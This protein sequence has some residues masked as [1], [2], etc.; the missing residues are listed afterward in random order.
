[1]GQAISNAGMVWGYA[2]LPEGGTHGLL[3]HNGVI[4]DISPFMLPIFGGV[5]DHG[6][7]AGT[8]IVQAPGPD[9]SPPQG[10]RAVRCQAI[11]E[12][13]V[14]EELDPLPNYSLGSLAMG[15]NTEGV[16]VGYSFAGPGRIFPDRWPYRACMWNGGVVTDL[17]DE[18]SPGSGWSLNV[19]FAINDKGQIAGWGEYEG[20]QRA[21]RLDPVGSIEIPDDEPSI[22]PDRLPDL[23]AHIL[24]GIADGGPGVIVLPGTGPIPIGP[25]GFRRWA[26][27][28][29][30]QREA[31][32]GLAMH[33]IASHLPDGD[34]RRR[35][36]REALLVARGAIDR[37]LSVDGDQLP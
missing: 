3:F 35:M 24:I 27:A 19:A 31:L 34:A 29:P 8:Q 6:Q 18:I 28:F 17:N 14:I 25:E 4:K 9:P 37:L 7:V 2:A 16:V 20:R 23:V 33:T 12:P 32:I 5:N 36:E 13:P 22:D 10:L 30:N 15:I 26:E 11:S 21:F 1:V